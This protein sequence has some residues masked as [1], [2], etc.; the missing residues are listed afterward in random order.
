VRPFLLINGTS[1][2]AGSIN[3]GPVAA[4]VAVAI[5]RRSIHKPKDLTCSYI[6]YP[7]RPLQRVLGARHLGENGKRGIN[8]DVTLKL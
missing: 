5:E 6:A 1:P 4:K 2:Y 8:L 7:A 3:V